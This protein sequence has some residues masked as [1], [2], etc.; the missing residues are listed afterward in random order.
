MR[1][2]DPT[3]ASARNW[4]SVEDRSSPTVGQHEHVVG[5]QLDLAQRVAGQQHRPTFVRE[6]AYVSAEPSHAPEGRGRWSARR[7]R[8]P[9]ARRASPRPGPAAGASRGSTRPLVDARLRRARSP[10]E[11]ARAPRAA[12]APRSRGCG[13]AP[14]PYA[15]GGSRMPRAAPR[16]LTHRVRQLVVPLPAERRG[17]AARRHQPEQH[18]QR[19]GL[20]GSVRPEQRRH[21]AR[22]RDGADLVDCAEVAEGLGEPAQPDHG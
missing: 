1:T 18:P 11:P 12:G 3:P 21:L 6:P 4:A 9:P 2:R 19:G 7:G 8:A 17:P 20:A 14:A 13:G 16:L 22:E 10:P 5:G 15:P